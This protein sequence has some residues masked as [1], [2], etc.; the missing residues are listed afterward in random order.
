[1]NRV[2]RILAVAA[3]AALSVA[4]FAG[5]G[6]LTSWSEAAKLSKKTGKPILADFTGSDWCYWCK[7]LD[8]EIFSTKE[9]KSWAAKNVVLLTLDF[10]QKTKQDAKLKQQNDGLAK[11]YG[12]QGFPT[13]LVLNASG[14]KLGELGYMEGGP[15]KWLPEASKFVKKK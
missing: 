7:K 10:P 8:S 3:V 14:D 5:E 15:S 1:M 4:S 6:W 2:A 9:F 12:I 11:K 13:V